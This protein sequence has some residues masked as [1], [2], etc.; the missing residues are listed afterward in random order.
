MRGRLVRS[1]TQLFGEEF[2]LKSDN[3]SASQ[4]IIRLLWKSQVH[5]HVRCTRPCA[6]LI[7]ST[8]SRL[9]SLSSIFISYCPCI[10][11]SVC[12]MVSSLRV[13][14]QKS[15]C[16]SPLIDARCITILPDL[17][18]PVIFGIMRKLRSC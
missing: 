16:I 2:F 14:V 8:S 13:F 4:D 18:I 10:Y 15:L 12:Q 17:I 5:Y 6:K 11:A 9:L 7:E 1:N 3:R